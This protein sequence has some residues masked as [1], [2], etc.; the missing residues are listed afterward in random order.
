M[1]GDWPPEWDDPEEEFP[2]GA[3]QQDTTGSA[4]M[5]DARLAEVTAYLASVPAPA[6]PD[7]VAARISAALAAE[8]TARAGD[9]VR[10][11][12]ARGPRP[13]RWRAE[14]GVAPPLTAA[15]RLVPLPRGRGYGGA[16]AAPEAT[17]GSVRY[18]SRRSPR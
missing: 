15:G 18:R 13:P 5:G 4:E 11:A 7:A 1:S 10:A 16:A 9:G 8:A 12:R 6:L 17:T 2:S 14:L 3:E